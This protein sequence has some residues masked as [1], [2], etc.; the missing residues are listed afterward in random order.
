M[1]YI[2]TNIVRDLFASR[3]AQYLSIC[4]IHESRRYNLYE[5]RF[6]CKDMRD[7]F[8]LFVYEIR[9]ICRI[10]QDLSIYFVNSFMEADT[11]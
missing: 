3:G 2:A 8:S 10:V 11:T 4:S 6:I 9:F 7:L 1:I 5:E